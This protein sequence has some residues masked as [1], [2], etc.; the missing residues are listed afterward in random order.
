MLHCDKKSRP[1]DALAAFL[2]A[3]HAVA[4]NDGIFAKQ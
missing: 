4:V 1:R 3:E 2:M